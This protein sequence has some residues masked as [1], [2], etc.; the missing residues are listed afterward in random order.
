MFAIEQIHHPNFALETNGPN[1]SGVEV[2]VGIDLT[3]GLP[4][5]EVS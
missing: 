4:T 3:E 2:G 5:S 1:H